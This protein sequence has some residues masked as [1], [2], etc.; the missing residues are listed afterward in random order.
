MRALLIAL[1]LLLS[2]AC[3]SSSA[4]RGWKSEPFA[5]GVVA[6]VQY[7]DKETKGDRHY[8][9]S[10]DR[11]R[12]A[13]AELNR[14]DLAFTI[15]LGDMIDGNK[16]REK[17]L[18]DLDTVLD[19]YH[20][21]SMPTYYV[22]GNHCLNAG[23]E[24][25][26]EKI[27][28]D[29]FYYDF[30]LPAAPG[31]RFV[32]LDGNDAGY[33]VLGDAQLAWLSATLAEA[34]NSGEKVIVFNHFP[35]VKDAKQESLAKNPV[36]GEQLIDESGCVVA[37]FAGHNHRGGYA[38]QNGVHH[39]TIHGMVEAPVENAYAVVTVYPTKIIITGYGKEPSRELDLTGSP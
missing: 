25:L 15:E 10:I 14:K 34:R 9:E 17:T 7:G 38:L 13:V 18:E 16:P 31:W 27:G 22:I 2:A 3:N 11:L 4:V 12:E 6:D 29:S 32:V 37:Y 5:F 28:L 19:V 21:L 39:V 26:H 35:Q 36:S 33:G 24:T 23:K 8:R 1:C 30:A 20:T